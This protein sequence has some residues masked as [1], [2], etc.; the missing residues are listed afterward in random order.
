MNK[1]FKMVLTSLL[2][3]ISTM[4]MSDQRLP[5]SYIDFLPTEVRNV[6]NMDW[7]QKLSALGKSNDLSVLYPTAQMLFKAHLFAMEKNTAPNKT[8]NDI[9]I[10][11]ELSEAIN[12]ALH[13][14]LSVDVSKIQE[15]IAKA[16][17]KQADS[18]YWPQLQ[19]TLSFANFH[20]LEGNDYTTPDSDVPNINISAIYT[21]YDFG[22]RYSAYEAQNSALQASKWQRDIT[23]QMVTAKVIKSYLIYIQY[24]ELVSAD[25]VYLLRVKSIADKVNKRVDAGLS[26]MSDLLR[27]KVAVDEAHN[28]LSNGEL[29]LQ[30]AK[31]DLETI[32]GLSN[33]QHR[34]YK[35]YQGIAESRSF[36]KSHHL[37]L[38]YIYQHS[39][40]LKRLK[41]EVSQARFNHE[42]AVSQDY[43]TININAGATQWSRSVQSPKLSG[44]ISITMP[45]FTGGYNSATIESAAE[46][47]FL[48]EDKL[49]MAMRSINQQ[50]ENNLI[51]YQRMRENYAINLLTA[52]KYKKVNKLYKKEFFSGNRP[53]LDLLN[54][55]R[56][57]YL[58]LVEKIK[59]KINAYEAL[60]NLYELAGQTH[61][62][63]KFIHMTK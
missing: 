37:T 13:Y 52:S 14:D 10:Y 7:S 31:I 28:F 39:L 42:E 57:F 29:R 44:S 61:D 15:K 11:V 22:K 60:V 54:S 5:L 17:L 16:K 58:T 48:A 43:P 1:F 63:L 30:N 46:S 23:H 2:S 18:K 25:K 51:V 33:D 21:I 8:A 56:G 62:V 50:L 40:L 38:N 12:K 3:V 41:S 19:G 34:S 27:S 4:A 59:D 26:I 32:T 45:I 6:L 35:F 36:P 47:E 20:Y 53:L 9:S 24:A 49:T 55:E